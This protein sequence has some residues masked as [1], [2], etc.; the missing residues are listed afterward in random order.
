MK[1]FIKLYTTSGVVQNVNEFS[2]VPKSEIEKNK[3]AH[4]K[5]QTHGNK[6]NSKGLGF[7]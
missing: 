7:K 5:A 3:K 6:K 4:P 2:P 1:F